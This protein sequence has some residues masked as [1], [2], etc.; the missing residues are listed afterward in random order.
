ELFNQ[1]HTLQPT[2]PGALWFLGL[3]AY[4]K[5]QYA[6]A[7]NLWEQLAQQL[8]PDSPLLTQLQH[9]IR[10]AQAQLQ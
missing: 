8:P 2:H 5:G 6:K 3:A 9:A 7:N 1:L 4:K 10:E